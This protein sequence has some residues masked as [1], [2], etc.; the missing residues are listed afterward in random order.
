MPL[1]NPPIDYYQNEDQYG[2]YQYISLSEL[3]NN[4]MLNYVGN[5]KLINNVTRFNVLYHIKRGIQEL[6]YDALKEIKGLEFD[7]PDSLI[8]PLPIDYVSYVRIS[9]VGA[10]GVLRPLSRST[11]T[12]AAK[13]YLQ[14][15]QYNI[16]FDQ[17]GFPLEANESN[18]IN[19]FTSYTVGS[20]CTSSCSDCSCGLSGGNYGADPSR[21]SNGYYNIN[22]REGKIYFSSA[23]QGK[24][25][26]IEY[27][28]DGLE[29]DSD[30]IQVHK[31]AENAL[32]NYVK[33]MI[34][35]NKF[36]VQEYI[37]NRAKKDY[38]VS[39]RNTKIRMMELRGDELVFLLRN[40]NKWLK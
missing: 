30:Q 8:F 22:K 35:T 14:D 1:V 9:F 25:I 4:F 13:A 11:S 32:Y 37:V 34:L 18:S 21:N 40:R 17:E 31:F 3:V 28:S 20:D 39:M 33:Y 27:V 26:M 7:V 24:T 10:D 29:Y 12:F 38:D 19:G 36:G 15:N 6:T 2:N 23:L 5:D 16:L